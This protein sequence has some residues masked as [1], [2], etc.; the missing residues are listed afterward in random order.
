MAE[1]VPEGAEVFGEGHNP[2]AQGLVLELHRLLC[3][4]FASKTFAELT[5]DPTGPYDPLDRLRGS[6][7]QEITRILLSS[8]VTARVIDDRNLG[9]FENAEGCGTLLEGKDEQ[10][11]SFREACNKIIHATKVRFD[12]EH[13]AHG[14]PY[15]APRMYF[16]GTRQNGVEWKAT[17]DVLEYAK[18]FAVCLPNY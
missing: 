12:R 1:H 17:L 8:A 6:E 14:M 7:Q 16:Y 18:Q 15:V 5:I 4:F 10:Q 11:L 3:I 13:T 2:D 9:W